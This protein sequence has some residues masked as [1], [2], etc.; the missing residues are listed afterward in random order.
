MLAVDQ[1]P[2]IER[3]V[4]EA[5]GEAVA[6]P[7]DVAAVKRLLVDVLAPDASAVLVDPLVGYDAARDSLDPHR[8]LLLTLEHAVFGEEPGGRRSGPIPRWGVDA[9]AAAGADGVKV[10]AWYRPDAEPAV[11]E[12]QLTWAASVGDE[13]RRLDLPFVLELLV[14]PMHGRPELDD[15]DGRAG[16]V[17]ESVRTFADPSLGVDLFKLESPVPPTLLAPAETPEGRRH[18]RHFRALDEACGRPWVV[19][20]A[21]ADRSDFLRVVEHAATAGAS[22]YLAGRAIWRRALSPFPDLAACRDLLTAHSVPFARELTA[23]T[24]RLGRPWHAHPGYGDGG[25]A[26]TPIMGT[27]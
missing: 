14:Y 17:L 2:P 15:V 22:G 4:A 3:L 20:S 25:P 23:I 8:G 9:I 26:V 19:L 12:H 1:R 21:G 13:C 16:A 18:Q 11:R 7:A 6:R 10:L 24:R 5:R 27:A